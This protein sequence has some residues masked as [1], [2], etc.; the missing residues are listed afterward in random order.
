MLQIEH[1]IDVWWTISIEMVEAKADGIP[2]H[3]LVTEFKLQV[4]SIP[5]LELVIIPVACYPPC[6]RYS[7]LTNVFEAIAAGAYHPLGI[8]ETLITER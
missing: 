7:C 1:N 3:P 6:P 2:H 4:F 5:P 8:I